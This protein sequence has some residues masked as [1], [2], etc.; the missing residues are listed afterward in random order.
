MKSEKASWYKFWVLCQ[1]FK[2]T[3]RLLCNQ[4]NPPFQQQLVI[5]DNHPFAFLQTPFLVL[6]LVPT[7]FLPLAIF[8]QSQKG[9]K[10]FRVSMK[11]NPEYP[12]RFH[13]VKRWQASVSQPTPAKTSYHGKQSVFPEDVKIVKLIFASAK[14]SP[15]PQK[16]WLPCTVGEELAQ[17]VESNHRCKAAPS[18]APFHVLAMLCSLWEPSSGFFVPVYQP[19]EASRRPLEILP[20]PPLL[21]LP[22]DSSCRWEQGK[23]RA[24]SW[25]RGGGDQRHWWNERPN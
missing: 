20:T 5:K 2:I 13:I 8:D 18:P 15:S 7:A 17:T 11:K 9:F 4:L 23:K 22:F 10:G 14:H 16:G 24:K 6:G 19:A 3:A 1:L 12:I 21:R 25:E